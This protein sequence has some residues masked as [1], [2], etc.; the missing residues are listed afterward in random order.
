[1]TAHV[2]GVETEAQGHNQKL[3]ESGFQLRSIRFQSPGLS[4]SVCVS[5]KSLSALRPLLLPMQ[6]GLVKMRCWELGEGGPLFLKS[7]VRFSP[8]PTSANDRASS[9]RHRQPSRRRS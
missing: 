1:M 8:L 9:G 2:S 3:L 5:C 7:I 6:H 4:G